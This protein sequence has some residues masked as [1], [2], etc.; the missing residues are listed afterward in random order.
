LAN[1][2]IHQHETAS[3]SSARVFLAFW[4]SKNAPA[5]RAFALRAKERVAKSTATQRAQRFGRK[6]PQSSANNKG[7]QGC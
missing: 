3:G 5:S 1:E 7:L 6:S 2:A 4:T